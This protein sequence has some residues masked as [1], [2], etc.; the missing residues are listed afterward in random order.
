MG[1]RGV[2]EQVAQL[3]AD[4]VKL[5]HTIPQR[6][7]NEQVYGAGTENAVLRLQ[8]QFDLVCTGIVDVDTAAAMQRGFGSRAAA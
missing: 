1:Q 2:G 8:G 6:E 4:L 3:Q 7:Q 5:G